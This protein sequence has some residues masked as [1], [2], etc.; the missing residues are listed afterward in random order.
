MPLAKYYR[1]R[2]RWDA[3]QTLTYNNGA[4]IALRLSPW[5]YTSAGALEYGTTIVLDDDNWATWGA[6]NTIADEGQVES[7]VIDNTSNLYLGLKGYWEMTADANSTDGTAYLYMEE[8]DDNTNWPSDQ[9]DFDI[10]D[11]RFV[12]TLSFSTT[13]EDQ[14]RATNFEIR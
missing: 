4:R 3:D 14:D 12:T 11:L 8:S 9:A 1:F 7:D 6:G 5:K 10:N 13:A 2:I